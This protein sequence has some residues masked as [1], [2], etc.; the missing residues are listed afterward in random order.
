MSEN[1]NKNHTHSLVNIDLYVRFNRKNCSLVLT[2]AAD[3]IFLAFDVVK[4]VDV[5]SF[6]C[7]SVFLYVEHDK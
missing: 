2:V 5:V 7:L 3:S 1:N 6:V 4:L